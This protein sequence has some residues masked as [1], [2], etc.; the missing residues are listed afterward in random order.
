MNKATIDFL[1]HLEIERNYSQ[2]TI[3]SYSKD[4]DKFFKFLA[5]EDIL[6]DDVDIIVIRNFNKW[7]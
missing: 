3:T 4:I 2:R 1:K 7:N 6:M 5:K